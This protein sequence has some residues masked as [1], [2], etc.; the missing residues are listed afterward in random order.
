MNKN[1]N[2]SVVQEL[3]AMS[4]YAPPH[5]VI[6]QLLQENNLLDE[7]ICNRFIIGFPVANLAI[8]SHLIEMH[9]N[10]K[11]DRKFLSEA[12]AQGFNRLHNLDN[13][14]IDDFF[15]DEVEI[16]TVNKLSDIHKGFKTNKKAIMTMFYILRKKQYIEHLSRAEEDLLSGKL[17]K[18]KGQGA[19]FYMAYQFAEQATGLDVN[20][21][22]LI[23]G[24]HGCLE[25]FYNE[26]ADTLKCFVE[27]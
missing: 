24:V 5:N 7:S 10:D 1:I 16:S 8:M 17:V 9:V 15:V 27:M 14:C 18:A 4:I 6:R 21:E 3:L 26:I 13:L 22:A 23:G 2:L 19:T 20:C 25:A 12:I 11:E